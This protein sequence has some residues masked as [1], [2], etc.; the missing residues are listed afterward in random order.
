MA[1][2]KVLPESDVIVW[3]TTSLFS[4]V[5]FVPVFMI[6]ADGLNAKSFMLTFTLG[7]A[8]AAGVFVAEDA[9]S[10]AD[11]AVCA[12]GVVVLI[13]GLPVAGE[14][15]YIEVPPRRLFTA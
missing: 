6:S 5:T 4:H 10:G 12:T 9:A 11:C 15:L 8:G 14:E 2:F 3:E 13:A 1:D 7:C